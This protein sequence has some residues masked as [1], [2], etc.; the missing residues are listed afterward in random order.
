MFLTRKT[1]FLSGCN[2]LAVTQQRRRRIMIVS[3]H[4]EDVFIHRIYHR[5]LS[6]ISEYFATVKKTDLQ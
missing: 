5:L 2:N 3:G 1:F 4:S 6:T